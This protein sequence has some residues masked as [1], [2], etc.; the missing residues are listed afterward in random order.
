[1]KIN[2]KHELL[3]FVHWYFLYVSDL[4]DIEDD[5]A[6]ITATTTVNDADY[7]ETIETATTSKKSPSRPKRKQFIDSEDELSDT[8]AMQIV[9]NDTSSKLKN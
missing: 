8:D 3:I 2:F 6:A 7:A 9:D 1:M 5:E 4:P